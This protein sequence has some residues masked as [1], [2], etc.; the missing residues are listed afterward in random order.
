MSGSEGKPWRGTRDILR[1]RGQVPTN[2]YEPAD[3]CRIV[4]RAL[5]SNDDPQLDH[6]ACVAL[7]FKSPK[8][9]L[10]SAGI[11]ATFPR[12]YNHVLHHE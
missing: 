5:Q 1:R 2:D 10:A 4:L 9:L 8:G 12:S 11:R 7:E 3:V 6:G